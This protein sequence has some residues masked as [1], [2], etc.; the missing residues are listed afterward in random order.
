MQI[1]T[2]YIILSSL[3][4]LL[5]VYIIFGARL[6]FFKQYQNLEIKDLRPENIRSGDVFVLA[7][8]KLIAAPLESLMGI[9]YEHTAVAVWDFTERKELYIIEY[10]VY[11]KWK[12][13]DFQYK[14]II[15]I[16]FSRWIKLNH[17]SLI[18][19]NS[20][21]ISEEEEKELSGRILD[22][23]EKTKHNEPLSA[24][25]YTWFR[26]LF[27]SSEYK[28][29]DIGNQNIVCTEYTV[30]LLAESGIINNNKS[31]ESYKPQDFVGMEGFETNYL[32]QK[33]ISDV[34]SLILISD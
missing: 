33:S 26:F 28:K 31:L 17:K 25:N 34:N 15:K 3:I 20:I 7:Y 21:Q 32:Y 29:I 13:E 27:P 5:F 19:H 14:G 16:P 30:Q 4:L 11:K 22:E 8:D 9:N 23:Y 1:E 24:F 10:A 12:N 2:Y 18:V 6:L